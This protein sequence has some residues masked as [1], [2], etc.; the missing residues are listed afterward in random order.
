MILIRIIINHT[1]SSISLPSSSQSSIMDLLASL[2]VED[3]PEQQTRIQT[4]FGSCSDD[5]DFNQ[6][7]LGFDACCT[8]G[9]VFP[10]VVCQN[11]HRVKYCTKECSHNDTVPDMNNT[12]CGYGDDSDDE[13]GVEQALGHTSVIC[14]LLCI[15]NDDEIVEE[16][17]KKELSTLTTERRNAATDRVVSEFESYPATL[18]NVIMEGP[19][20]QEALQKS[21]RT[22][23]L[24]IHVIGSSTDSELWE[25]HPDKMQERNVFSCYADALAEIAEKYKMDSI[26]L[27]FFGPECPKNNID[28]TFDIPPVQAKKSMTKLRVQTQNIDYDGSDTNGN[29]NNQ[30]SPDILV[31]FNPGFTC[32]DYDW[33]KT[34]ASCMKNKQ[35]PF[36]VTT[37]TEMEA[38]ADMQYLFDRKLFQ[39]IS[40]TLQ[41]ILQNNDDADDI[42][43]LDD[44][45][46]DDDDES[47]NISSFFSLNPYCGLRVRQS[48][49]MA[50]DLYVKSRWL[51][52][53]ISGPLTK[54]VASLS[55]KESSSK[56]KRVVGENAN[57]KKANPA[58]V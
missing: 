49:T 19:C 42:D 56:R 36:L 30:S 47:D 51:F 21:T 24:T 32:P 39:D 28:E 14:A 40:P 5:P 17:D 33:E 25:G 10:K 6:K 3:L 58:L 16:A 55:K 4:L 12:S 15:C 35:L 52:G 31:F 13:L 18:A 9:K 29:E 22:K 54:E 34:L 43:N 20:Y 8:C 23:T 2:N 44:D 45:N 48:G 57:N 38:L 37:N 26:L 50:N 46:D 1:S 27:Q 7:K 11:C 53:G 41:M